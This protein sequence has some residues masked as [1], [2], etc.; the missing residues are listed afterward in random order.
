MG[1]AA[2]EGA[3][4][5]V[6]SG[7]IVSGVRIAVAWGVSTLTDVGTFETGAWQAARPDRTSAASTN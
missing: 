3:A 5:G 2:V 4:G 7:A 1:E 6:G